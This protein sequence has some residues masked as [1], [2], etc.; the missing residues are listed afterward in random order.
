MFAILAALSGGPAWAQPAPEPAP[1]AA[2]A[3]PPAVQALRGVARVVPR[4]SGVTVEQRDGVLI[5]G[6]TIPGAAARDEVVSLARA[7]PGVV[8]VDDRMER[9]DDAAT[10]ASEPIDTDRALVDTIRGVF[11][12]VPKLA[13]LQVSSRSGVVRLRGEVV[14]QAAKDQALQL[15]RG[16]DG[17]V[18]VDDEVKLVTSVSARLRPALADA[19]TR[20]TGIV[21][22]LPVTVVA[23]IVVGFAVWLAQRLRHWDRLYGRL[24]QRPLVRA[25]VGR[26]VALLVTLAGV[27]AGLE[28]LGATGLVGAVVGTAGVLGVAV[29]FAF[30]DIVEN[31][32]AGILLSVQQ[33]FNAD[34]LVEVDNITGVVVRMSMRNT[35]IMTIDGNHV[36]VPN[37]TV[38]KS[39]L[40][41]F[42]RNPRRRF[43]FE[44]GVGVGE[45]LGDVM[46]LGIQTLKG[47][48]GVV[49]EPPP[50][51]Y[52]AK[53]GDSNVV[54]EL[55]GWVDQRNNEFLA[56]RTEAIRQVKEAFDTA[57]FDMPE[58]IYRL[59]MVQPPKP[60]ARPEPRSDA[61]VDTRVT[62]HVV[63]QAEAERRKEGVDLLEPTPRPT[64]E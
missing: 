11:A 44:V 1:E 12:E 33:P 14:D 27:V 25:M 51:A 3:P 28:I 5:L 56:V 42:T 39:P 49:A 10:L 46:R 58:P 55:V 9:A 62:D 63:K 37:A 24:R 30:R 43:S 13:D 26:L 50:L 35:L 32:L 40:E 47:I 53:L 54:I 19:V 15:V 6:G 23:L 21:A 8:F 48:D 60:E 61:P 31:Y 36:Y 22:M 52:I 38:F 18:F 45:R 2:E 34:D 57:G 64:A 41:N 20:L 59:T 7:Q 4:F 17:V 16:M 29:G